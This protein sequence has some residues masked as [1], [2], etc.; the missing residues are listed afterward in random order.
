MAYKVTRS[1][2][3]GKSHK[4]TDNKTGEVKYLKRSRGKSKKSTKKDKD[5]PD[6]PYFS[7]YWKFKFQNGGEMAPDLSSE[8]IEAILNFAP[9]HANG[10]DFECPPGDTECEEQRRAQETVDSLDPFKQFEEG[11][12]PNLGPYDPSRIQTNAPIATESR[13]L[14][15]TASSLTPKGYSERLGNTNSLDDVRLQGELEI[16]TK[17]KKTVEILRN[18]W[19]M[20]VKKTKKSLLENTYEE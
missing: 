6:N 12:A 11:Q 3:K 10:V 2:K 4:V 8:E 17:I 9:K 14:V 20:G 16:I 1:Y 18:I 15:N 7:A 5:S 19:H 13:P